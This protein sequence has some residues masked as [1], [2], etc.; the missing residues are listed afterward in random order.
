MTISLFKQKIKNLKLK[1]RA[2]KSDLKKTIKK[3]ASVIG[4]L[5]AT[6]TAINFGKMNYREMERFKI[7]QLLETLIDKLQI[8][9]KQYLYKFLGGK[10]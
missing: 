5:I 10:I 9:Q 8:Y 4:S 3:L 7:Q 2:F 6:F 1:S